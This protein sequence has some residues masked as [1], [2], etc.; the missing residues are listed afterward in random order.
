MKQLPVILS[1]LY[2]DSGAGATARGAPPMH[3]RDRAGE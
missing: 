3:E 2:A 1:S